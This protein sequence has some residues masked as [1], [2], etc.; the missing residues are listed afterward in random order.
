VR[1]STPGY[2][3]VVGPTSFQPPEVK[4]PRGTIEFSKSLAAACC[5]LKGS[6]VAG[7]ARSPTS[8]AARESGTSFSW[9]AVPGIE[10]LVPFFATAV[11]SGS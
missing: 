8:C 10:R 5:T 9:L 1:F 2:V 6:V 3:A 7:Y 11:A 4:K